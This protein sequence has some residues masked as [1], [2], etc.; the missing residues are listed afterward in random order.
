MEIE[1]NT[2]TTPSTFQL[3]MHNCGLSCHGVPVEIARG[4]YTAAGKAGDL[5]EGELAGSGFVF[6]E[7]SGQ[8][9]RLRLVSRMKQLKFG[10]SQELP[11][12]VQLRL[13]SNEMAA[14]SHQLSLWLTLGLGFNI[15]GGTDQQ[16][17]S[18]DSSI[19]VSRIKKDGAAYLDG[20]LQE[21]DKILAYWINEYT[22]TL[23][24]GVFHSGIEIYGREF[25][26]GGHP[27]PFSGIFEITPG[28]AVELGETF[29]FK[30]SIALGTTDFTEEDV[31]KIMEELGKE[32][33]GNA[34][35]LMHKN[36]NHFS[37]AL[38]EIL[39]GKEIPRWVNR[40]AYF[41]SCIPF[42]QSCLPKEW[43]TPAALQSHISLGLHKEEQGDTTDE[44]SP[45]TSAAPSASGTSRTCRHT[46][47]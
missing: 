25:A 30:E 32:Y 26:Y 43:L 36:C 11:S 19:Y 47:V 18:N 13:L 14:F 39:C 45:S 34:Y 20:R 2:S 38:A 7:K 42:L 10:F 46:R 35:H 27:Y 24:I 12:P 16:Y 9:H 3:A 17:V 41:S 40:L 37:A 44:E 4:G 15:V 1:V 29:K 33:K 28:S 21:G 6:C 22:S 8:E 23:G 31:D 5:R